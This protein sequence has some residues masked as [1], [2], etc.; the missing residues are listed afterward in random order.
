MQWAAD[1]VHVAVARVGVKKS[2]TQPWNVPC[3]SHATMPALSVGH[4]LFSEVKEEADSV[5]LMENASSCPTVCLH[6]SIDEAPPD[7]PVLQFW[8]QA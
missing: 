2:K 8:P 6:S 7:A 3:C 5:N 4:W 1:I